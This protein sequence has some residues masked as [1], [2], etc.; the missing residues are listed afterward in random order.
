MIRM[1][2]LGRK[3]L[4]DLEGGPILD[5]YQDNKGVWTIGV[6]STYWPDTGLPVIEGDRIASPEIADALF[7]QVLM[8]FEKHVSNC[9][10]A[11]PRNGAPYPFHVT[12]ALISFCFNIGKTAFGEST[13]LKR[14]RGNFPM[15]SV[16]EAMSW[17]KR[18]KLVS[19]RRAETDC[20]LK[21]IYADQGGRLTR[22]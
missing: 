17:Y 18:P 14:F 2:P 1:T 10:D 16:A 15:A 6:G 3:W 9:L 4:S 8:E 7:S 5:A 11:I 12:D 13:A 20:L 19:R 21:G 22:L